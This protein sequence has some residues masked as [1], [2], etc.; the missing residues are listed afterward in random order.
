M[1]SATQIDTAAFLDR[2]GYLGPTA[3]TETSLRA[4]H[5]AH[6]CTV[7]FENLDIHLGRPIVLDERALFTKI[8]GHR[9][10]GFCYELNGLFAAFLRDLGFGVTMLAAQFP[11]DDGRTAPEM[12]HLVLLVQTMDHVSHYWSMSAPGAI[13]FPNRCGPPRPPSNRAQHQAPASV[14]SPKEMVADCSDAS[15]VAS[16]SPATVSPGRHASSPTSSPGVI[17][18]KRRPSQISPVNGSV[19]CSHHPGESPLASDA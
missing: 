2:I 16:G 14:S 19:R 15:R 4:L 1:R 3:P 9:R 8:V 7:P 5:H 13:R 10:G 12:D 18:T 11:R 17:S 6:L